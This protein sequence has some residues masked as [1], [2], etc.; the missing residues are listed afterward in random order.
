MS[1]KGSVFQKGGGGTN[2]EQLVQTAFA[3]NLII[4]G[5][6]PSIPTNEIIEVAFQTTNRG[7]ETDDLLIVAKSK[8]GEHRLLAQIK[9]NLTF[10]INN[11]LFN[12]VMSAF[13]KDFNNEKTFDKVNDRL[14]FIKSGLNGKERSNIKPL[15]N[16]ARTHATAADFFSEVNRLKL[17]KDSLN[18][19][20]DSL[21]RANGNKTVSEE[22]LWGFLRC[23]DVLEYD[24]LNETSKDKAYFLNLIK[25]SKNKSSSRSDD[26]IWNDIHDYVSRLNKDGGSITSES[27]QSHPI[28][29]DFD[30]SR[31]HPHFNSIGKLVSD[32]EVILK[33][34]KSTIGHFHLP[35]NDTYQAIVESV[36]HF[37]LTMVTGKPGAG[38][39]AAVKDVLNNEFQNATTFVFRADQFNTPHLTQ[40]FTNQGIIEKIQDIFSILSLIPE[41]ILVIDSLEKLLEGDPEN[42]FKQL[43]ALLKEY[44]DIKIVATVRRYSVDLIQQK[45][46]IDQSAVNVIEV[47]NLN[48]EEL[49]EVARNFPQ[50]RSVLQNP[51][52]SRLL[53]SPKYLDFALSALSKSTEDFSSFKAVMLVL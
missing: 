12:E 37:Q 18:I 36:G 52:I 47:P 53:E 39:S 30:L 5:N 10:S 15:F 38:K 32:S 13:W 28:Y 2:F 22:S 31:I 51:Q 44:S 1:E 19:F 49:E 43:L 14:L 25:L 16:W 21:K 45:F 27:I 9:H 29:Q 48:Q 24:L 7:Y 33:P 11:D 3:S 20:N 8:T 40:V 26:D 23:V 42:A 4:R 6:A 34:L 46:G 35:K 41:K 50:L 17:K